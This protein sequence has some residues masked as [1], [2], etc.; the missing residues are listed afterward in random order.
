[1]CHL[2]P[3]YVTLPTGETTTAVPVQKTS[4][5]LNSS[6]TDTRRSSTLQEASYISQDYISL[7]AAYDVVEPTSHILLS[8][9]T[10][11]R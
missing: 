9:L 1:M 6:S 5:A 4:S 8:M 3:I 7:E 2:F 10:S 11:C